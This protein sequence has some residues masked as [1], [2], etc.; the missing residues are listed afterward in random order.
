ML[1]RQSRACLYLMIRRVEY[2]QYV[3]RDYILQ[4]SLL[5]KNF[6]D[7]GAYDVF[8]NTIYPMKAIAASLLR[9]EVYDVETVQASLGN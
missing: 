5:E 8:Y 9:D 2:T 1:E 6:F 7:G 4:M 3:S